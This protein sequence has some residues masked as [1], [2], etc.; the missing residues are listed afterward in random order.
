[1][2]AA[3]IGRLSLL[4]A[5]A[6]G[7][8]GKGARGECPKLDICGGNPAS[9][10]PW[11]VTD[12]CQVPP[13]R[14][15]QPNDV[16]DFMNMT[17]PLAPTV[18]PPQPNPIVTQQTT[19]GD[20]CSNLVLT[21][22]SSGYHV[23]NGNLWHDAPQISADPTRPSTIT[24]ATDHTYLTK[25][26]FEEQ[27]S[28][29]FPARCLVANGAIGAKCSPDLAKAL[30]TFYV[31]P[32]PAVRDTFSNIT[33]ADAANGDGCDCS[34]TFNLEV[35][36]SGKWALDPNDSTILLQDSTVLEFNGMQMNAQ[37]STTMLKSS[38]CASNGQ[39]QLSGVRGG[40]LSNVQGLNWLILGPMH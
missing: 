10:T 37:A 5:V 8:C 40:S 13:V 6:A 39:L 32:N 21:Q 20:W 12:F 38:F 3:A 17:P 7:G 24:L 11:V 26:V 34:Y 4:A 33:C 28:T 2:T 18:A 23:T 16:N 35:D 22:D 25:L 1:L 19:S 31:S 36:D 9:D 30:A 29:H 27:S 14:P 15:S